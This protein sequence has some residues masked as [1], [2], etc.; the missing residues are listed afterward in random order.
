MAVLTDPGST[1]G[2]QVY[3]HQPI[4]DHSLSY[5]FDQLKDLD[6]CKTIEINTLNPETSHSISLDDREEE[7]DI[8]VEDLGVKTCSSCASIKPLRSHHCSGCD[9]CV[10]KMDHHCRNLEALFFKQDRI[11][12]FFSLDK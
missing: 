7:H 9:R 1:K 3:L 4:S 12:K 8:S 5:F 11:I 10:L 2:I 6:E